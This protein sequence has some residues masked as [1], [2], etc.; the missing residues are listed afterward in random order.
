MA[1][2]LIREGRI[3]AGQ[4]AAALGAA[5][6]AA[7]RRGAPDTDEQYYLAALEALESVVPFDPGDLAARKR[8]WT[9]AYRRTPHGQPVLLKPENGGFSKS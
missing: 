2:A 1:H 8:D 9:A 7:A 6:S 5:L 3:S 4:W